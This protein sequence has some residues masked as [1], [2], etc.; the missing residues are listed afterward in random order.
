MDDEYVPD[1]PPERTRADMIHGVTKALASAVPVLGGP[2]AEVL[3][4]LF[5][6]TLDARKDEWLRDIA[7]ELHDL[8]E[9]MEDLSLEDLAQDPS[10]V[11]TFL[12]ASQIAMRTHQQ[13]K[14]EALKNAVLNTALRNEPDEDLQAVFLSLIDRFTGWHLRILKLLDNPTRLTEAANKDYSNKISGSVSE[15]IEDVFSELKGRREFYD[16]LGSDLNSAGLIGTSSFH[17]M[18]T[19]SGMLQR[20]TSEIGRQFLKFISDPPA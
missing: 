18:I 6:P 2:A 5:R 15:L 16:L 13:E 8:T 7:T 20:R 17:S 10:F 3:E 11:T 1:Q 19:A 12:S 4:I 9:K 14:R